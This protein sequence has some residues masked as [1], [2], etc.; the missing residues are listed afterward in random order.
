[1]Y[2][3]RNRL[4]VDGLGIPP[5]PPHSDNGLIDNEVARVDLRITKYAARPGEIIV[6]FAD[7]SQAA[8]RAPKATAFRTVGVTSVDK[9][10]AE[11]GVESCE[12]LM[13]LTGAQTFA[14]R[15]RGIDG[16]EVGA[17]PMQ[18]AY[19]LRLTDAANTHTAIEKLK[20]LPDVAFAEPNY[21]VYS[22]A[23]TV[24]PDDPYY[25]IQYGIQEINLPA[26]WAQEVI[27]K[28]GPVIAILDTGVD[29]YHPDLMANIWQNPAEAAGAKG[30]DDD[31]NGYA[32]DI[33]G[34]DFVNESGA[35]FDYNGHGTHCAGIAAA[36]AWNGLGIVG[37]NPNA[38]IMP[39]TVLQSNGTGDIATIIRAIDYAAAAGADII[40]MSLGT[41]S[42]SAALEQAL[43]R[44]Y[45][46]SFIVAAAGNDGLCLNH[47][48]PDRGQTAPAPMFP[49]AY[50][51]VLGVQASNPNTSVDIDGKPINVLASF[52]NY[53]DNGPAFSEYDEERLYNYEVTAPGVS[54]ISTFPNGKYKQLNGTSMATPL[55]AGALSR[56]LQTKRYD[57]REELF[58]DL[59]NAVTPKGNLDI[60]A[61]YCTKDSDR[62]PQLQFVGCELEDPAGDGDG[63]PD[64]GE[65]VE[66][67]PVLRNT[68]GTARN[69]RLK[70]ESAEEVNNIVGFIDQNVD[71]GTTLSSYGKSR[72]A[73]PLRVRFADNAVDGRIV[74]LRL[75][76]TA[77]NADPVTQEIQYTLENGVEIGGVIES[78]MTLTA[79]KT[80]N[81]VSN[82]AV[83]KGIT[84]TIEPGTALKFDIAS[85][86]KVDGKIIAVGTPEKPIKFIPRDSPY[87]NGGYISFYYGGAGSEIRYCHFSDFG[88]PISL[89]P[90]NDKTL[91]LTIEDC[92]FD[93][94]D[95]AVSASIIGMDRSTL[96]RCV[97]GLQKDFW[98]SPDLR[99]ISEYSNYFVRS[100]PDH[101][102]E[103]TPTSNPPAFALH[104]SE[105]WGG[106]NLLI[107]NRDDYSS[108]IK[109]IKF[110]NPN[111]FGSAREE[112]ARENIWDIEAG[113]GFAKY[114]LSN[115]LTRPSSQAHG[116]VWK[117]V[118]DGYDA[119]DEFEMLPPLGVGRHKFE[120][121]FNRRMNHDV[122]PMLAMGVRAPYTQTS[123]AED[124]EWRSEVMDNGDVVDVYT[125]WLTISGR[126]SFDG[127]N[128]I[129]VASAQDDEY[130]EIPLEDARF[131]VMVQAAGSLSE[132]FTAEAGL[133]RVNL[134]WE[135]SEENFDDMLG[136]NM[137]RYSINSE[138][139]PS[140][141]IR[142][143]QALIEAEQTSLTDYEVR[144]GTTYCYYYKVMRTSM[145][146][147]SPSKTVAVTPLTATLGDANGSGD[148]DVADVITT[149]NYAAGMNP[150]PFIFEAAD[151]NA[152]SEIDILDVVGIIR[153]IL[154]PGANPAAG[155]EA[156]ASY[157]VEDG[158]LYID[159]PVA[160]AGV[161]FNL[162]MERNAAVAPCS[163]LDGF[164]QAGAWIADNEYIFM[165]YTLSGRRIE[166]GRHAV[167]N[168]GSANILSL[169][170]SD[171]D[172]SNIAAV[173]EDVTM[174]VGDVSTT[175][176]RKAEGVYNI[177]GMRVGDNASDLDHL[178]RGVYIVNGAKV[179]K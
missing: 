82:V 105:L 129:Y 140:D 96:T 150:K 179:V 13:P 177:H 7:N 5:P 120:V 40:S 138:G 21:L 27:S 112:I 3:G 162:D 119:Q 152:D 41:Y 58:G 31:G 134:E 169:K 61:A 67:Y 144:P 51:F 154:N 125:A 101:S 44:A 34:W 137:Y 174:G 26:L 46:K 116:I 97:V 93:Y 73:L 9:V 12:E 124:G 107:P 141:T 106:N 25:S 100:L 63:R 121:Y 133:G 156:V 173:V 110:A 11:I 54:V 43:G 66:I 126:S 18:K 146:E 83:P 85:T 123:I 166:P 161:Q 62:R 95:E 16:R 19:R 42:E 1:M 72:S 86:I 53:D 60:Y 55:V 36:S 87:K 90:L 115:M 28:D 175:I 130:F 172:G 52:S 149:V 8:M 77:D 33:C 170:L 113:H 70:I 153:R 91:M 168:I 132:G 64:A 39:L 109:I 176:N 167:A 171:A 32:D 92:L 30:Y 47:Q 15:A 80:Y 128:R 127:L 164:E 65:I 50:T 99:A 2:Y 76:A 142:I 81:V 148:V 57:N 37:A 20:A 108:K 143:N 35:I 163:V 75:T 4:C 98:N 136:Y 94:V 49:A 23:N 145:T 84:L 158:I 45:Q 17:A 24:E 178:P 165:A 131:N 59:I 159:S 155:V 10:M 122:A 6:K 79:D 118:V 68:W 71:F 117:V 29:I 69:V 102:G 104:A 160:I 89:S 139:L 14:H 56:L 114:D 135:N 78:D 88:H 48:H 151:L 111:Y 157:I 22:L 103:L 74:R 38:R 147:N